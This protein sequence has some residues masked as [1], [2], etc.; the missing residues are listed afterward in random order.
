MERWLG[1]F[2]TCG[3]KDDRADCLLMAIN[4]LYGIPKK[5]M[6]DKNGRCIK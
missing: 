6:T 1:D 3:K 4:G 5:Q 2:M